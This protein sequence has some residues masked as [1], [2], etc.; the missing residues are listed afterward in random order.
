MRKT[1]L[2]LISAS[3]LLLSGLPNNT[4]SENTL[5]IQGL[6]SSI[7]ENVYSLP[8]YPY[9]FAI[10][11]VKSSQEVKQVASSSATAKSGAYKFKYNT[12]LRL[13]AG[14]KSKV[15]TVAKKGASATAT[16]QKKVGSQIWYKV[17]VNGKHGWVLSTLLSPKTSSA[18]ASTTSKAATSVSG[19]YKVKYNSNVRANAG[20]NYK[21]V[22]LAK[23][24]STVKATSSK[25][26]GSTTWFKITANGKTGWISGALL[27]KTTVAAKASVKAKAPVKASS[28]TTAVSGSYKV[29]YNSNVR[30]NAGTGYKVVTSA[31]KGSTVKATSSKKVGSI[32]W[33]KITANGKT[34]WIS[35]ALL[36]KT[37]AAAKAPVKASSKVT[38]VSGSYK[39]NYN[40][41]VRANAGTG[42]KIVTSAKKGSIV[43]A[44]SS[45]K[46]GSTTWFKVTANGKIGWVSGALL[47]KTTAAAKAGTVTR[48]SASASPSAIISTALSLKGVPYRFGGTTKSG[49]DCSGF[50]QYVFKQHG[51][52]VSRTTLTQF[53]ETTTVS[54]PKPGDLVFFANTYRAGISHVGIYIGNNQFVHSG[55]AKAEVKSL[56]DVYWGPK[57]HS[58]KRF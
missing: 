18:K 35:G 58:F 42:Y 16:H 11:F 40:S 56:N 26:V 39:V 34:G 48:A 57:F 28:K 6:N 36:T 4:H 9:H 29:N 2:T 44:T 45:K 51:I 14:T 52:S 30:A 5:N 24:G 50:I 38:A 54:S 31:K 12:N 1:V 47:T 41:N 15:L 23:K 53:A 27:T 3:A 21:A 10:D 25:K 32:T 33:F 55:G 19:A 43:K 37:T 46:V 7:N 17:K 20:T 49:F 8:A 22:T 13:D